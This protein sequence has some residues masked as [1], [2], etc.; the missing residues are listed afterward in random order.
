MMCPVQPQRGRAG[1]C[2]PLP[3]RFGAPFACSAA[4]IVLVE[5]DDGAT[6]RGLPQIVHVDSIDTTKLDGAG[7][8]LRQPLVTYCGQTGERPRF[9]NQNAPYVRNDDIAALRQA[10]DAFF[11]NRILRIP[12]HGLVLTGGRSTRMR[13]DKAALQFHGK[14]QAKYCFD[15]LTPHCEKVYISNRQDQAEA[16]GHSGLP[17]LHDRYVDFG[18]MGGILTALHE[19]PNAAWLVLACDLPFVD[20]A[21]I[22]HLLRNR[23]AYRMAT[24]F[25]STSDGMPEPL[26][27]VYEP[28]SV[29]S[30]MQF[31]A[32]GYRCPRKVLM[33]KPV[34][35]LEQIHSDALTNVN[36]TAEYQDACNRL[37]PQRVGR[38]GSS[39]EH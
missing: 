6:T 9:L 22:A 19:H 8:A 37:S 20:N 3:D 1:L 33:N 13:R 15:V 29:L 16:A 17:Q 5:D 4:D 39:Q 30:F 32:L 38:G 35:I 34:C 14:S 28:K 11:N 12:I 2:I 25:R 36:T 21:T 10:I 24:A 27:A 31:A 23:C 26:C 7:Q 18:P